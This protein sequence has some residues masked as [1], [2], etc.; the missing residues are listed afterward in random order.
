L[1]Q[2]KIAMHI[3]ALLSSYMKSLVYV[4]DRCRFVGLYVFHDASIG[5]ESNIQGNGSSGHT[6]PS[7]LLFVY[8]RRRVSRRNSHGR[9]RALIACRPVGAG[10]G[11]ARGGED[12]ASDE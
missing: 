3:Q 8:V 4:P 7:S 5:Y 11:G 2:R 6:F 9:N 10:E 1:K 12:V